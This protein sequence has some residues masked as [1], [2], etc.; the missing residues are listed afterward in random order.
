MMPCPTKPIPAPGFVRISG[1][2]KSTEGEYYV[3][4]GNGL[5]DEDH[6]RTPSSMVWIWAKDEPHAFDVVAVRRVG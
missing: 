2:R 1:K 6:I 5:V 4:F 3:Q